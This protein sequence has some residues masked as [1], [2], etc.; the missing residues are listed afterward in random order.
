MNPTIYRLKPDRSIKDLKQ[1]EVTKPMQITHNIHTTGRLPGTPLDEQSLLIKT[2][3]GLFVVTGCSHPGVKEILRAA[4]KMGKVIGL[5]GGL[6]GFS[7]FSILK[8]IQSIYPCHC[9]K[10]KKEIMESFPINTYKC[11]VGLTLEI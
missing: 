11:G 7:D 2:D 1:I 4:E 6:H 9:T 3:K 5:L 8:H 10:Y